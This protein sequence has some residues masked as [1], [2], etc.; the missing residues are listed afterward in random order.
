MK[1][2]IWDIDGTLTYTPG[3]GRRAMEVA[4]EEKFGIQNALEGIDMAGGLDVE[5]VRQAFDRHGIP[6]KQRGEYFAHYVQV[7][8]R[9][10]AAPHPG[11]PTPGIVEAL[12]SL[13]GR[14]DVVQVL[15]TGNIEAGAW[16]KLRRH[17]LDGYFRTGGFGDEPVPR[18]KVIRAAIDRARDHHRLGSLRADNIYVIGDTPR[19][20]EAGRRL[21]V[22]TVSVAT[23]PFTAEQLAAHR[24]DHLL[25]SFETPW[26]QVFFG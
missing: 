22:Q 2:L 12:D 25:P 16:I 18:W 3:V 7:L 21:G 10:L 13:S 17:G 1:L 9:M 6:Q 11:G 20:I 26:Q 15:G 19:D 4:F 14:Q 8:D 5:I 24:P 23:G